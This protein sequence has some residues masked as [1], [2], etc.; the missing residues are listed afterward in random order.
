MMCSSYLMFK[1][2]LAIPAEEVGQVT[3]KLRKF[4]LR[5]LLKRG[6]LSTCSEMAILTETYNS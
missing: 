6:G 4:L 1:L 5:L 3:I 2:Y